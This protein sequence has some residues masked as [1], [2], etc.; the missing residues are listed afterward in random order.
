MA[1]VRVRLYQS[2][3]VSGKWTF[4]RAPEQRLRRL[5]QGRYYFRFGNRMEPAGC[6]P[7]V[8]L[9]A[10]RRKQAELNFVAVGGEQ[11]SRHRDKRAG[12]DK[13]ERR[14]ASKRERA[15]MASQRMV[16]PNRSRQHHT[17]HVSGQHGFATSPEGQSTHREEEEEKVLGLKL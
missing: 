14:E 17:D 11:P 7:A 16:F 9:A 12:P 3:K 1:N 6:D 5:A 2:I 4:R 8:A 13:V 10:L 15:Q